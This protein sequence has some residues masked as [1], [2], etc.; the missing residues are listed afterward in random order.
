MHAGACTHLPTLAPEM[1]ARCQNARIDKLLS[2]K[3]SEIFTQF[4]VPFLL[5]IV[6]SF[7]NKMRHAKNSHAHTRRPIA[8]VFVGR[9]CYRPI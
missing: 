2:K 9:C 1:P 4:I 8:Q 7:P 5:I 3:L 6:F